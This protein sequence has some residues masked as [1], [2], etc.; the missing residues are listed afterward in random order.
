MTLSAPIAEPETE[1]LPLVASLAPPSSI[2][3]GS[4]A[5]DVKAGAGRG[6]MGIGAPIV[7]GVKES[8]GRY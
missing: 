1:I 5:D 8:K 7:D 6:V 4:P 3:V 2:R